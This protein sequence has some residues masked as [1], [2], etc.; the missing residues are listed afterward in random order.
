MAVSRSTAHKMLATCLL[1][2]GLTLAVLGG[3]LMLFAKSLN[4]LSGMGNPKAQAIQDSNEGIHRAMLAA[5][6]G[7][8]F[9]LALAAAGVVRWRTRLNSSMP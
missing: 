5:G 2:T 9:G 3:A 8:V 4:G 1:A 6:A 7:G